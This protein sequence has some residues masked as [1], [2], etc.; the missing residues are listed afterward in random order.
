M[1]RF[2]VLPVSTK[3]VV[4][5]YLSRCTRS[6]SWNSSNFKGHFNVFQFDEVLQNCIRL[7]TKYCVSKLEDEPP[8]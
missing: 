3:L 7:E 6:T 2:A 5:K 1:E 4:I 8:T